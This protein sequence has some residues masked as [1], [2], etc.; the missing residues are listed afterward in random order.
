MH[1]RE[2]VIAIAFFSKC[3]ASDEYSVP[4]RGEVIRYLSEH[5]R[6][7]SDVDTDVVLRYVTRLLEACHGI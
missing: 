4:D 6:N 3:V 2:R 1:N 5:V 7:V